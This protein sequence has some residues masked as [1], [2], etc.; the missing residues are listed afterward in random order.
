VEKDFQQHFIE[1][2]QIPHM[3]DTF[4]HLKGIVSTEVLN[5]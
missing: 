3:K 5:Q 4:P 1:A 2:L